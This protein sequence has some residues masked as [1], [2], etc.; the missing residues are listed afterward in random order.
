MWP[1]TS[2]VL[3]PKVLTLALPARGHVQAR[4]LLFTDPERLMKIAAGPVGC[5]FFTPARP[6]PG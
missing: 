6:S 4:H 5:K 2:L 1:R 3:N